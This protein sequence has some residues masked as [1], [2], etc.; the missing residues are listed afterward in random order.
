MWHTWRPP[1]WF[2]Y[3]KLRATAMWSRLTNYGQLLIRKARNQCTSFKPIICWHWPTK[4][5]ETV[6]VREKSKWKLSRVESQM[7][8]NLSEWVTKKLISK[9]SK[10]IGWHQGGLWGVKFQFTRGHGLMLALRAM[11]DMIS[12]WLE[13]IIDLIV[14]PWLLSTGLLPT[15]C[16]RTSL[17]SV[18]IEEI[19]VYR[20]LS[21]F[22][23]RFSNHKIS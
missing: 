18:R 5:S 1:C 15:K 23:Q 13:L 2:V 4:D 17:V 14:T 9:T 16:G 11:A 10:V 20:N 19:T 8:R 6:F 22:D 3:K 12:A 7:K 21:A